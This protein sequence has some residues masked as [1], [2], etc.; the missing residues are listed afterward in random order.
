MN[1]ADPLV[2][3]YLNYLENREAFR[4]IVTLWLTDEGLPGLVHCTVGKD[5]TG[6]AYAVVLDA[7]GVLRRDIIA[8][9]VA[10]SEDVATMMGRLRDMASYGSAVDVYP[11]EAYA[12]IP[13]TILRF[14]AWV[15]LEYGGT[16]EYLVSTGI[17]TAQLDQLADRLLTPD[18]GEPMSQITQA[19][20]VNASADD[21]WRLV[22]DV[23]N[24]HAWVPALS[25]TRMDGDV[26]IAT[27]ADGG[28][29]RE[30]IVSRSDSDR[31]YTY[32]YLDGPIPLEQYESTITVSPHHSG[33][34]TLV[35]W[36]AT[37]QADPA[38]VTSIDELYAASLAELKKVVE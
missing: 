2:G 36:T 14:L 11:P 25:K 20:V 9:Y 37:L 7:L 21:V 18:E 34:G 28:E 8:N 33:T 32:T 3:T 29:A 1:S 4:H 10:K 23:G 19:I 35:T 17:T 13:A 15:D 24:V 5:R 38:V 22:G 6:V 30:Q 31:T 12:S 16:R 27:F 26:R